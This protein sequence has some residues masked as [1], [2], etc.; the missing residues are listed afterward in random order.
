MVDS[1][2]GDLEITVQK[3]AKPKRKQPKQIKLSD[4]INLENN[5]MFGNDFAVEVIKKSK[6][7]K[8]EREVS[9][10]KKLKGMM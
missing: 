5:Q 7:V 8:E 10:E 1:L 9:A 3:P 4:S 2:F 6:I